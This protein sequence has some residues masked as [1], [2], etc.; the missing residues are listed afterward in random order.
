MLNRSAVVIG[1]EAAFYGWLK[2]SGIK[3][4]AIGDRKQIA[5]RTV[6]LI[7]ACHYPEEIE[8]VVEDLF[9]EIF[10]RELARWQPDEK[11]WP[12]TA[13]FDLFTRW[14]TVEGFS[15]VE[16]IGRGRVEDEVPIATTS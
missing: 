7:P 15:I 1:H 11:V 3:D 16:D 8:E 12:D 14:F 4:E 5:E 10:R 2:T 13:D 6:Y 9:E